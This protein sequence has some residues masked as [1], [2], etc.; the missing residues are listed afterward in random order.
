MNHPGLGAITTA[1]STSV[2]TRVVMV[3]LM[4]TP[5]H[6]LSH[7]LRLH[8]YHYH[9]AQTHIRSMCVLRARVGNGCRRLHGLL[10]GVS[11]TGHDTTAPAWRRDS[12]PM[13]C[14]KTT[15]GGQGAGHRARRPWRAPTRSWKR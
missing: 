15:G 13:A 14:S 8:R 2:T 12:G 3:T 9:A 7:D 11:P 6:Q 4:V 5:E 10:A 1:V